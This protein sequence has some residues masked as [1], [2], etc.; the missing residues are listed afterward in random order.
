MN[1]DI[2]YIPD[3]FLDAERKAK[4]EIALV[5]I[6]IDNSVEEDLFN[7]TK[8]TAKD[9]TEEIHTQQEMQTQNLIKNLV[10]DFNRVVRVGTETLVNYYSNYKHIGGYIKISNEEKHHDSDETL[11]SILQC[12]L[13]AFLRDV[14][15]N[16]W[17]EVL[18]L[19]VVKARMTSKKRSAFY[20]QLQQQAYMDFTEANIR[21]FIINIINGYEQTL[22]DAVVALFD[23][24]TRHGY[25]KRN[26]QY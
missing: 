16:Y 3:A 26:I 14:R 17:T 10:D 19:D 1:A 2:E 12:S 20:R 22:T 6:T 4:V 7:G 24:M 25:E 23:E 21:Q 8:D 5:H 15:K 18:D 9:A 13:N 11:T